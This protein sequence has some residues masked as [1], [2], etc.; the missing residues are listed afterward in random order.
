M[1]K[2]EL[3]VNHPLILNVYHVVSST[4][5]KIFLKNVTSNNYQLR[6]RDNVY[7]LNEV[8]Y[9]ICNKIIRAY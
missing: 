8:S 6:K 4:H 3:R 7:N 2:R 9:K 1:L 5:F